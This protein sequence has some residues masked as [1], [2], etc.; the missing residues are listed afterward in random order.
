MRR[1]GHGAAKIVGRLDGRAGSN[2]LAVAIGGVR[3]GAYALELQ[4][5]DPSGLR[6]TKS[7]RLRVVRRPPR[8]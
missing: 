6:R 3:P 1:I 7:T 4:A 8:R 2:A 5:T